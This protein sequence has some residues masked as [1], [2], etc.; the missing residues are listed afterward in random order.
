MLIEKVSPRG[1]TFLFIRK[2]KYILVGSLNIYTMK[3][4]HQWLSEYGESHQNATNKM[5]HYA[6]VPVIFFSIV[7]LFYCVSIPV[8]APFVI[9]LAHI[10]LVLVFFYYC[11]MSIP[12]AIGMGLFSA[13]CIVVC[14]LIAAAT[15][16]LL[17]VA[18]SLF[19][20]AWIAQFWGHKVE[21]KKPSFI[22]DIQF[23]MIGPAWIMSF[24]Y[25]KIGLSI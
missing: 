15:G 18:I 9:T 5:V 10:A 14:Q 2:A 3:S 11:T 23:L 21:G 7:A 12:L 6:C 19:V 16:Q 24:L 8:P 4:I 20:V 17:V 1:E 22:K 25:K 13:L